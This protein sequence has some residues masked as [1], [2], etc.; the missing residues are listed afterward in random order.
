MAQETPKQPKDKS[1]GKARRRVTVKVDTVI[2][3]LISV[4]I[5]GAL[6]GGIAYVIQQNQKSPQVQQEHGYLPAIP[7]GWSKASPTPEGAM[8][9]YKSR[10]LDKVEGLD[11][12]IP[13]QIVV[14]ST[15]LNEQAKTQ[16][17]AQISEQYEAGL[18]AQLTDYKFISS[19][20]IAL[21]ETPGQMLRYTMTQSGIPFTVSSVYTV[22]H[23][24]FYVV[25][26]QVVTSAW[27][28]RQT[29]VE[30]SIKTFRP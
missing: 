5:V 18:A 15:K 12:G 30:N 11:D 7:E 23:G 21:R 25:N 29:E 6:G 28:Q 13:A 4:L 19:E 22:R 16:S 10:T 14:Q 26:G 3:V 24:N 27:E 2:T 17:F 20:P 8:I 1:A 9:A